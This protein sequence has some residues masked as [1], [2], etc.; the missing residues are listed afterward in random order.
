MIYFLEQL[1]QLS[2]LPQPQLPFFF[3]IFFTAKPIAINTTPHIIISVIICTLLFLIKLVEHYPTIPQG[4]SPLTRLLKK[5]RRSVLP[6]FLKQRNEVSHKSFCLAFFKKRAWVWGQ[7][8]QDLKN[9]KILKP[10]GA[11]PHPARDQS[12]DPSFK[13]IEA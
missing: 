7:R 3:I 2:Q 8:H 6:Q 4:T 9:L 5:L 10:W 13:K 11:A 1:Q 12:L